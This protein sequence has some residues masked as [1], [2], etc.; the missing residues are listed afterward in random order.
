VGLRQG[1]P[2]SVYLGHP[3]RPIGD[4]R[5]DARGTNQTL[6]PTR[7]WMSSGR[8]ADSTSLLANRLTD[9]LADFIPGGLVGL[10]LNPDTNQANPARTFTIVANDATT[11]MTDPADGDMLLVATN[12][13]P[14]VARL[15]VTRFSLLGGAIA[16]VVDADQNLPDRQGIL[17]ADVVEIR[18]SSVLTHPVSSLTNIYGLDLRITDQLVL[19]ATSRIDVSGRGYRGSGS[20]GNPESTG[21]T[22]GNLAGSTHRVGGSHGGTGGLGDAGGSPAPIYGNPDAPATLGGGGGSDSGPGGDGGGRV[23]LSMRRAILDGSILA[24]GGLGSR[25]G[26]GGAGG[27]I[28]IVTDEWTGIGVIRAKGGNGGGQSGG[29]GGGRIALK[30]RQQTVPEV[31]LT[32]PGGTGVNAGAPGSVS[33]QV[34]P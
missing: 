26:G 13:R 32:A 10:E 16:E 1:S 20:G 34:L 11:I 28:D 24:D 9:P 27:G 31:N 15:A 17:A 8:S 21:R 5:V 18:G 23:F 2:G 30:Y 12:G 29:G 22:F 19:D 14:Y 6:R 7:L 25:Y 33:L 3:S 4:L